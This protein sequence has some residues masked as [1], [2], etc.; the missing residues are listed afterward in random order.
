[1][2][3]KDV[4]LPLDVRRAESAQALVNLLTDG[5]RS[6]ELTDDV[7]VLALRRKW[8]PTA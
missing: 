3:I 6:R 7:T 5:A 4:L 1:M 2:G 8:D